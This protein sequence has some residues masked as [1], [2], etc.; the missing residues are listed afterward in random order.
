[1]IEI[2][3]NG[4]EN[5]EINIIGKVYPDSFDDWDKNFFKATVK[6]RFSGFEV[7]FPFHIFRADLEYWIKQLMDIASMEQTKAELNTIEENLSFLL[8]SGET[9]SVR[10]E[11]K[12]R[13]PVGM[14][15]VFV[16]YFETGISDVESVFKQLQ[17][18]LSNI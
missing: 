17:N 4:G 14:G 12:F 1:M 11:V 10:W 7:F 2:I 9:G 15:N 13:Y 6:A 8:K 5:V 3:G 18:S 16:G